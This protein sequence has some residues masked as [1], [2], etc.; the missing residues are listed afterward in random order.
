[1]NSTLNNASSFSK[2]VGRIGIATTTPNSCSDYI[3]LKNIVRAY[4]SLKPEADRD[5]VDWLEQ[6]LNTFNNKEL[7][8][9]SDMLY[10]FGTEEFYKHIRNIKKRGKKYKN[11]EE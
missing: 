3:L 5:S 2:A 10:E 11:E 7:T 1:M 4:K 8:Q 6:K 9:A